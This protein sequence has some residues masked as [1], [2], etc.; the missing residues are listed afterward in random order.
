MTQTIRV[1]TLGRFQVVVRGRALPE[2][3]W[4]RRK[5][6]QLFKCLLSR[7]HHR[8]T[9]DEAI[10]L[11]WPDSDPE[12]GAINLRSAMH[13]I[14]QALDVPGGAT[15]VNRDVIALRPDGELWVDADAFERAVGEARHAADP[16]PLLE[17][18]D[19]LYVGDY[20]P[21][22]LYEDWA[23]ERREALK[24][25]W[26]DL[27]LAIARH[28]EQQGDRDRAE[29]ALQRLLGADPCDERAAQE[30][31]RLL[32]G[33][34]RRSDALHVYQRLVRALRDDLQAEP[35]EATVALER[36]VATGR[37]AE[38]SGGTLTFLFTDIAGSTALLERH[39]EAVR[40]VLPRHDA[41]LAAGIAEHGGRV[42]KSR[43]EGDSF[44]AVFARAGDAVAAACAVQRALLAESWPVAFTPRVRMALH[45]GEA[46]LR[47]G[48]YYGTAVNRCARLRAIAH[49]G[50]ILLSEATA[51][52]VRDTLPVGVGLRDLGEHRLRDL[53][54]PERVFQLLHPDL[55]AE[56]PPLETFDRRAGSP[57][58]ALALPAQATPLIGREAEVAATRELLLSDDVR[59]L[60]LTGPG[61]TGKT[62]LALQ[63]AAD[64]L[65]EFEDGVF[66]VPL[67]PIRDANLVASAIAQTLE[68]REAAGRTLEASL[69]DELRDK[70]LLLVLDNFEQVLDA[71][72]LVGQLLAACPRLKVLVTSRAMLHLY[73]EHDFPVPPLMLPVRRPLPP[74]DRLTRCEAVRLFIERARAVKPD[75]AV[76][77]DNAPEVAEICHRL[78]GLPLAIELAAAR[79]RL[80][81][82]RALLGRLLGAPGAAPLQLLTGGARDLPA[83]QQTLR[84]T[85]A[86]SYDLLDEAEQTL[87]RRL[88]VFVGSCTIEAAE[89]VAGDGGWEMAVGDDTPAPAPSPNSRLPPPAVLD[90]LASLVDNSLLRQVD[91]EEGEPR[92]AMLETIREYGLERLEA[93]GE[94]PALRRRH[95]EHYLAL[96]EDAEPKLRGAEQAEWLARLEQEHDNLRAAL[97]WSQA[98]LQGSDGAEASGATPAVSADVGAAN[99]RRAGGVPAAEMWLRLAGALSWF[100]YMRGHISDGR[101]W[102]EGAI[103]AGGRMSPHR[104]SPGPS[105]R[106]KAL[107]GAGWL[108]WRQDEYERAAAL[109]EEALALWRDLGDKGR[110]G[111]ALDGLGLVAQFRGDYAR[112]ASIFEDSLALRRELG[113]R[114]GIARSLHRLGLAA[115][116]RGEYSRA[117]ALCEEGVALCRELGDKSGIASS[118]IPSA[119]IAWRR[120]EYRLAAALCGEIQTL[121]RELGDKTGLAY[122][123]RIL[124]SV[125]CE[126]GDYERA[127]GL[128]AESLALWRDVGDK[129]GILSCLEGLAGVAVGHGRSELAA[130]L[131]G[132]ADALREAIGAPRSP[133]EQAA[134]E[135]DLAAVRARL[136]EEEFAAAWASGRAMPLDTAIAFALEAPT[137]A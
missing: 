117:A 96:A 110:L 13:A 3:A 119:L 50:Q 112:A 9:R 40:T 2:D 113:D 38:L 29:A 75:F 135:R 131:F 52:L 54:R 89:A 56:F 44:F 92:F 104:P 86:W 99:A 87:F 58:S 39:P 53:T 1:Y 136:G 11:L 14:R 83:R 57:R 78:D 20:L 36:E 37:P 108:A 88:A 134:H 33:Q 120:G 45:T 95:A 16:L 19:A 126:Q 59:L 137:V 122:A 107:T 127:T 106:A 80:L 132:A 133:T 103:A 121:C 67:A 72:P 82:P 93:S 42:V 79:I 27:Q 66:L 32:A 63:L 129:W 85:I 51:G 15:V 34:G 48:D 22:D 73:G 97:A 114:P 62:R 25:A 55:P 128:F 24:R 71:V 116:Y 31:M 94:A 101:R 35:S 109:F 47:A 115:Y 7:R 10:E 70:R 90:G 28:G 46:E 61:G 111:D 4:R 100:W 77:N 60:T 17:E 125:A 84:A 12:A 68:V 21:D 76:T 26:A 65:D 130:R 98:A 74:L 102:L 43:G 91:L 105:A 6:R 41:L 81:P 18:A 8:L 118:L 5:A 69:E 124:G 30:L 123:L 49:G 64:V 23:A